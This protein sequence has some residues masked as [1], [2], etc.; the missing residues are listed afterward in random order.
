ML[1]NLLP[2]SAQYRIPEK[3][4]GLAENTT[5]LLCT[6]VAGWRKQSIYLSFCVELCELSTIANECVFVQ[7][8]IEYGCAI[9]SATIE[10]G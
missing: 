5:C 1:L 2:Q 8:I 9:M 7:L 10:G 4:P 3:I 6:L